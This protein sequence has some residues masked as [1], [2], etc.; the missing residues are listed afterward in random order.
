MPAKSRA[1][2][3]LQ[4]T[5]MSHGTLARRASPPRT[6]TDNDA[7]EERLPLMLHEA[8]TNLYQKQNPSTLLRIL[9]MGAK[10]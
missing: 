3:Q 6:A 10:G 4:S 9:K 7:K 8:R 2:Q 5:D 1:D